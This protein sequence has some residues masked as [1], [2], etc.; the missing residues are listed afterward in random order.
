MGTYINTSYVQYTYRNFSTKIDCTTRTSGQAVSTEKCISLSSKQGNC[1]GFVE[2]YEWAQSLSTRQKE[3][4]SG[5]M[6]FITLLTGPQRKFVELNQS[7]KCAKL[8]STRQNNLSTGKMH[9]ISKETKQ[10][11]KQVYYTQIYLVL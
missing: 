2:S 11:S 4:S 8:F 3:F 10:A 6:H 1:V 7:Q 9:L 5:K